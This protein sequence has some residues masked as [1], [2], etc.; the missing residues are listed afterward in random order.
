MTT[1][2]KNTVGADTLRRTAFKEFPLLSVEPA[3]SNKKMIYVQA[4]STVAVGTCSVDLSTG[5]CTDTAGDFYADAAF[6]DD[7]YGFVWATDIGGSELGDIVTL[8]FAG[9]SAN[10]ADTAVK[11][12]VAPFGFT[13]SR[14]DTVLVGGAL[15]T[16]DATVTAAIGATDV[17]GGVVTITQSGSAAGDKDSATPTA[18]NTG[19]SGA[20]ITLTV[21]GTATGDRTID[22][23]ITLVRT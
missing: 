19:A 9:L 5:Q 10:G 2:A 14:I 6:A 12:F 8:T 13:L 11:S 4:D 16:G 7:E 3:E 17:T 20:T 22:G 18:L 1:Y 15:A 21:G 23:S